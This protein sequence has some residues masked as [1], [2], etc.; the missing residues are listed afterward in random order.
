VG[1]CPTIFYGVCLI[2]LFMEKTGHLEEMTL[3]ALFAESLE[4]EASRMPSEQR[5]EAHILRLQAEHYRWLYSK[6]IRVWRE[7]RELSQAS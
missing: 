6:T 7:V 1:D 2:I 3:G 4:R 5:M